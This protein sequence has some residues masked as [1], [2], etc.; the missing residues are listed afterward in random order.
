MSN[1]SYIPVNK[2]IVKFK[3]Y[4]LPCQGPVRRG[5]PPKTDKKNG[6]F[7][8]E[9]RDPST[10]YKLRAIKNMCGASCYVSEPPAIFARTSIILNPSVFDGTAELMNK[11]VKETE[12]SEV[13]IR[14]RVREFPTDQGWRAYYELISIV[15]VWEIGL[16]S[17]NSGKSSNP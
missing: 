5:P 17:S 16:M 13:I 14:C 12:N 6:C 7:A 1:I 9:T 10:V 15:G 11:K 4:N 3:G 8:L 2:K